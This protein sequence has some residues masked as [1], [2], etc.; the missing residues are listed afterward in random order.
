MTVVLKID[1][2]PS[3]P[4]GEALSVHVKYERRGGDDG[5]QLYVWL[6]NVGF[7]GV[8]RVLEVRRTEYPAS[9]NMAYF[10]SYMIDNFARPGLTMRAITSVGR[11]LHPLNILDRQRNTCV[12][13]L[14]IEEEAAFQPFLSD[15]NDA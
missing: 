13:G 15:D 6:N 14:S 5:N 1:A 3:L 10:V 9:T 12:L 11:G 2:E 8:G 4:S 7:Y